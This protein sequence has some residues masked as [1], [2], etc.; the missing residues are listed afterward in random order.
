MHAKAQSTKD[1]FK[2]L[3]DTATF[4]PQRC[5]NK[6]EIREEYQDPT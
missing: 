1:I 6:R 3:S 5:Q 2:K 4:F